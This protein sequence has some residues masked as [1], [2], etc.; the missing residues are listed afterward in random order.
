MPGKPKGSPKTGGRQKGTPNKVTA[1]LK[2]AI[3]T[4][5]ERAH[6]GG[7]VGYL[8]Q[9]AQEN[10]VAFMGL[11]GKVLPLTGP[12]EDG[13]HLVTVKVEADAAFARVVQALDGVRP[14]AEGNP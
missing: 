8:V 10:P 13:E 3:L 14:D 1:V 5:A 12:G 6:P 7:T 2:N 11:L 9:Q 4:A